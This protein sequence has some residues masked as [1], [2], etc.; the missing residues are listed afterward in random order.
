ME[1]STEFTMA[2]VI[3]SYWKSEIG[4]DAIDL[5]MINALLSEYHLSSLVIFDELK[6]VFEP[7]LPRV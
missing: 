7:L 1:K 2:H 6:M 4:L 5:D 3:H